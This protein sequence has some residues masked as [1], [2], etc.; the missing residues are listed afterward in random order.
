MSEHESMNCGVVIVGAGP[1]GLSCA[2][3]L[4]NLINSHNQAVESGTKKGRLIN[5][6][7]LGVDVPLM[8]I[9][10]GTAVGDHSISGAVMNPNGLAELIPNFMEKGAPL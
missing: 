8:I 9:E 4:L 7:T 10:K 1:A 3:H 2:L 5:E 6:D